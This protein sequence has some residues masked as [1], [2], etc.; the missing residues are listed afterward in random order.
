MSSVKVEN[1]V[2]KNDQIV[3]CHVIIDDTKYEVEYI[4]NDYIV[5]QQA[6][7]VSKVTLETTTGKKSQREQI[8][9]ETIEN[10]VKQLK[11]VP[12]TE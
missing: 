1:I 4:E 6:S 9:E 11:E 8:L 3:G 5:T 12:I 10:I 7:S 2:M